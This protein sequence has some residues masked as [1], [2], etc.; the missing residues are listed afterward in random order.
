MIKKMSFKLFITVIVLIIIGSAGYYYFS[1]RGSE[2]SRTSYQEVVASRGDISILVQATG[3]VQPMSRIE[4]KSAIAG[5]IDEILVK[6]GDYVKKGATLLRLS[7]LERAALIDAARGRGQEEVAYWEEMYK[8][9]PILSPMAG[10]II[11]KST[12]AG[13]TVTNQDTLMIVA[14]ALTVVARVDETDLGKIHLAQKAEIALEAYPN[15]KF[16]GT[17]S[18]I[19]FEAKTISNVT[20][21]DI[22]LLLT[23]PPDVI[24]SGMSAN[25]NFEIFRKKDLITLPIAAI[26]YDKEKT[27]VYKQGAT[28]ARKRDSEPER[29]PVTLD[30]SDGKVVAIASGVAEGETVF[31]PDISGDGSGRDGG[32]KNPFLPSRSRKKGPH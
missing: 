12:E 5:R 17:V 16:S 28:S 25:V 26:I 18:Q 21:Y 31:I 29:F 3:V 4:I 20:M 32:N 10:Q 7:S 13:Q 14:D 6:E 27:F 2:E 23:E 1:I 24:R 11:Q 8:P 22:T 9:T 19:A 15:K 30:E